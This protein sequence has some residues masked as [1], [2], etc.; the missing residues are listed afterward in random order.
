MIEN[1]H[2]FGITS[3]RHDELVFLNA[4]LF[5]VNIFENH[6]ER[7]RYEFSSFDRLK[8]FL[9]KE[10]NSERILIYVITKLGRSAVFN[11]SDLDRLEKLKW[12]ER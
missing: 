6:C 10:S 5:V 4:D 2:T 12:Q 8:T 1:E 9:R 7:Q 3:N 11:L